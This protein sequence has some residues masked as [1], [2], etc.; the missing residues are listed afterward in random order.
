MTKSKNSKTQKPKKHPLRALFLIAIF[1]GAGYFSYTKFFAA[2]DEPSDTTTESVAA[3]TA[4]SDTEETEETTKQ[5]TSKNSASLTQSATPNDSESVTTE[6]EKSIQPAYETPE[7]E[8]AAN[9]ALTGTITS[10]NKNGTKLQIRVS[11]NQYLTSG[12]CALTLSGPQTVTASANLISV[13]STSTCE[14][15]DLDA[16]NLPS[17]TYQITIKLTSGSQS[18]TISGEVT[19]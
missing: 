14:G 18:G 16:A 5:K 8:T 3:E 10:A 15:F 6:P 13:A 17:G 2:S 1:I 11:I 19:L 7:T 12:T 9:P 4:N